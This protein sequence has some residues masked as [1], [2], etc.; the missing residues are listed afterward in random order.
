[1]SDDVARRENL[2]GGSR[3][4]TSRLVIGLLIVIGAGLMF[5]Q[6][7]VRT[8]EWNNR[9]MCSNN[10]WR[11]GIALLQEAE[12]SRG[13]FPRGQTFA[14]AVNKL[15]ESGYLDAEKGP[16][17][18]CPSA[19]RDWEAWKRTG[20]ISEETCSYELVPGLNVNSPGEFI[21]A[22]DKAGNHRQLK[23]LGVELYPS[24]RVVVQVDITAWFLTEKAF[25][26][27]MGWQREMMTRMEEGGK[28]VEWDE[29][30]EGK[31]GG[32]DIR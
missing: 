23:V 28:V 6:H 22:C 31:G 3:R 30:K 21:L 32:D 25:Q 14:E 17:F 10:L 15:Y 7:L 27:R 2:K 13:D 26:E 4:G 24:M 29:W 9:A 5:A 1:M 8:N 20:K 11:I 18:I 12:D 19:K 16:I